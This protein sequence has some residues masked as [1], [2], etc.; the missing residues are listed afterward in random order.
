MPAPG[1]GDGRPA[2]ARHLDFVPRYRVPGAFLAPFPPPGPE[3]CFLGPC[4]GIPGPM[5]YP[6]ISE[7]FRSPL[8]ADR[9]TAKYPENLEGLWGRH[10]APKFPHEFK[11]AYVIL[12]RDW[13]GR[14]G[15]T[16]VADKDCSI[17]P[18]FSRHGGSSEMASGNRILRR[19]SGRKEG[20][21]GRWGIDSNVARISRKRGPSIAIASYPCQ[22]LIADKDRSICPIFSHPGSSSEMGSEIGN[23]EPKLGRE[24]MFV[25]RVGRLTLIWP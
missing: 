14:P 8:Y 5:T 24:A 12:R 21:L 10:W 3:C 13:G 20:R 11:A 1:P 22:T 15:H 16:I 19:D 18:I 2:R 7:S 17:L 6:D 25:G 4:T 9:I 23:V